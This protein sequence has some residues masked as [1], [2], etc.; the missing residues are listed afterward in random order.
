MEGSI[1]TAWFNFLHQDAVETIE[2]RKEG[3]LRTIGKQTYILNI[4]LPYMKL[5]KVLL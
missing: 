5:K 1:A 3:E 4:L 2:T